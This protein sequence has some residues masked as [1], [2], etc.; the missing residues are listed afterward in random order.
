MAKI[1]LKKTYQP[2]SNIWRGSD[3]SGK[4]AFIM[5]HPSDVYLFRYLIEKLKSDGYKSVIFVRERE[6]MVKYLLNTF[7]LS[8]IELPPARYT[9]W[10][11]MTSL[12]KTDIILYRYIKKLNPELMVGRLSPYFAQVS[13]LTGKKFIAFEDSEPITLNFLLTIPFTD[14]VVTPES[15]KLNLKTNHLRVNSYKE[16]A[17]LHPNYFKPD[18]AVYRWLNIRPDEKFVVLRFNA[19]DSYHDVGRKGF[20]L[21]DKYELIDRLKNYAHVFISSELP[22]PKDLKKYELKVP[23]EKMHSVLYYAHLLV[24]DTGTIVTEAACLG[25]PAVRCSSLVGPNDMSNFIELEKK[26]GLIS[27]Y[28]SPKKAIEKAVEI[29]KRDNIKEVWAEK[30]K[31]LLNEKIDLTA[32]MHNL[33][34][35]YMGEQT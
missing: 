11:R 21:R 16:L 29:I 33:I 15:F 31:K 5:A 10:S 28:S 32:Y 27:N 26:Y 35:K 18:P 22:L 24:G 17:Y 20:S 2:F 7:K 8:Y 1:V 3:M 13:F 34:V 25:T 6:N 12:L 23:K 9:M 4:I 14:T 19:F 30:R